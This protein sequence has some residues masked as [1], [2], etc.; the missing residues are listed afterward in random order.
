MTI[1]QQ[2]I[3][4][5]VEEVRQGNLEAFREVVSETVVLLRAYVALFV[6]DHH[7]RDDILDEV[8]LR[9]YQQIDRY[10]LGSNFA[11]WVKAIARNVAMT[12]RNRATRE[13]DRRDRYQ[14]EVVDR[15]MNQAQVEEDNGPIENQLRVLRGC[16]EKLES[17]VRSWVDLHYFQG[18]SLESVAIA[19]GMTSNAVGVGL[20]R[21]RKALAQCMVGVGLH[22]ARKAL[23]QCMDTKGKA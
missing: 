18:Q 17:R 11:A 9:I 15:L 19:S 12:A 10:E 1:D 7:T 13:E 2:R 14:H 5:A 4:K 20:H 3:E 8:Y 22:R 6:S 23:A 16:L 21:A